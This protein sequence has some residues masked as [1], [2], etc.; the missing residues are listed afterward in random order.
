M[1]TRF[2]HGE[3]EVKIPVTY[4]PC[5]YCRQGNLVKEDNCKV[6]GNVNSIPVPHPEIAQ[7][8]DVDMYYHHVINAVHYTDNPNY[9]DVIAD[10]IEENFNG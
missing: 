1:F 8:S 4:T 3:V 2:W 10:W 6:C 5:P 9:W 7:E